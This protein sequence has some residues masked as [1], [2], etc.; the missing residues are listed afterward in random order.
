[1]TIY[2]YQKYIDSETTKTLNAPEGSTELCTIEGVTYVT[3]PDGDALPE[4]QPQQIADSI[5]EVVVTDELR[6]AIKAASPHCKLIAKRVED[7]IRARYSLEDELYFAR[8]SVGA[9]TGQYTFE[10]GEAEAVAAFGEFVEECRQWG[11]D[12]RAALGL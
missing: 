6:E 1:M 12:Q 2:K 8:I 3:I 11:R 5:E 4:G 10:P 7:R 9:L